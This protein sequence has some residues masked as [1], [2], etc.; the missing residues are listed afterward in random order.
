VPEASQRLFVAVPMPPDALAACR[1]LLDP[2]RTGPHARAVRWV[3]TENLHLT[4]RFLGEVPEGQV[5]AVGAAVGEAAAG[6]DAFHVILAGTGVFPADRHP[7]TIWLGIEQGADELGAAVRALDGPL[8]NLGWQ[9]E[10]RPYRPHVSIARTDAA[11]PAETLAAAEALRAAADG[12]RVAFEAATI[13]LYRSHL[14]AGPPR[15]EPLVEVGLRR[16]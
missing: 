16:A 12:W 8:T 4:L 6:L 3:R 13:A 1:A 15:Y 2:V 5:S 10:T 11:A 14:G 9:S 7:R